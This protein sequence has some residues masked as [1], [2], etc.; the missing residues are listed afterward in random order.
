MFESARRLPPHPIRTLIYGVTRVGKTTSAASWPGPV[1]FL[2][3][4]IEGGD[5]TLRV[6]ADQ[7]PDGQ[8]MVSPIHRTADML[9]AIEFVQ[10]NPGFCRTV[11]V[12]S[13]SFYADLFVTE[14]VE[15]NGNKPLRIQDWG[16][17]E[18]HIMKSLLPRL[19]RLPQHV[20]WLALE[21]VQRTEETGVVT[22]GGPMLPGG[23]AQKLPAMTDLIIHMTIEQV[24]GQDG[25]FYTSPVFHMTPH[26]VYMAGGRYGF[27]FND[28]G[29]VLPPAFGSIA[30]R[31]GIHLG[32]PAASYTT[33]S[34]GGPAP[35]SGPQTTP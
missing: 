18:Q 30:E 21:K 33:P 9:K 3:V 24:K 13:I 25:R 26:G 12:D 17:L 31:I 16:L 15:R 14:L 28:N 11:V 20:V 23:M 2:S 32:A 19:H 6:L 8:V 1:A 35:V 4:A 22:S 27:A 5:T 29:G 34:N 7:M 10:N